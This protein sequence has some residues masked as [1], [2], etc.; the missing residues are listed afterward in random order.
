[1]GL[2]RRLSLTLRSLTRSQR[3]YLDVVARFDF[4]GRHAGAKVLPKQGPT[5]SRETALEDF[6]MRSQ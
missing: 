2:G 3:M 5:S 1:M 6:H 4:L